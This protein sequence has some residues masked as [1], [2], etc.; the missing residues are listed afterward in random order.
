[1]RI[2]SLNN[3]SVKFVQKEGYIEVV[4]GI[5]LAVHQGE[6]VGLIGESGSGKSVASQSITQLINGAICS[7]EVIYK[8]DDKDIDLLTINEKILQEVRRNEISYIFQEPMTALNPLITCGAQILE[9]VKSSGEY[10]IEELLQKVELQDTHRIKNS[11]PHELSGGQRQRIM[12]AMALAKQ[13]KLLIADEPTTALDIAI[14]NEILCL[15]KKLSKDEHMGILFITHDLL[16]LKGFA[17]Q[18]AVM[19]HGKIV[20]QGNTHQILNHPKHPY[21]KAL[22]E[23]RA[24]YDKKGTILHEIDDLLKEENGRLVYNH[25]KTRPLVKHKSNNDTILKLN[26]I[27]KYHQTKTLFS[28]LKNQVLDSIDISINQGDIIGLIGESGSGKSTIAKII[29]QLW[30]ETSGHIEWKGKNINE[31][32]D[33]PEKIQLVFQDPFSSLNP[34]HTIGQAISEVFFA[35]NKLLKSSDIKIKTTNLLTTVGLDLN[36]YNKYPHQ[37]SGGQR[38]RICIAK[39]LAKNPQFIVLDEAVSA[40]DVSVQ[41]KIINLLNQL[42]NQK[43]LTYLLISHDMNVVSYFCNKIVVLKNGC[44]VESG[45]T[46]TLI[47]SPRSAYTK[48]L[49]GKSIN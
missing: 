26:Q 9:S 25:P 13:P 33:L 10:L 12:I 15:L 29:L 5:D 48:S 36:D 28:N 34:K 3:L 16:S 41:A 30:K 19:F 45:N 6:I 7:G 22:I 8:T 18:I 38:Q 46:D 27:G 47:N 23:S 42:K 24:T 39:A 35:S 32:N 43:K 4:K 21:T 49:L 17:D 31:I 11:Y 37:F 44:I 20:E 2:L 14:Q 1:M 40:L